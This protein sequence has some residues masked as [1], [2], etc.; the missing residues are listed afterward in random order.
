MAVWC[1]A[2]L[3]M[4]SRAQLIAEIIRPALAANEVVITDRFLL[5]TVVYQGHAGGLDPNELWSVGRIAASGLEP[6]LSLVLDVPVELSGARRNRPADRFESRPLDYQARVRQGFLA[7]AARR[8]D[9]IQ[10]IDAAGSVEHVQQAIR[11][12]VRK[13]LSAKD[14]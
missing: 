2:L 14:Q 4:A 7:E 13:Q 6:D 10:V 8:P 3:F 12:A 11:L 1:E 5:S 9:R